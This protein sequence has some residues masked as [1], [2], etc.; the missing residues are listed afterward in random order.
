MWS[1]WTKK[2]SWRRQYYGRRR[3]KGNGYQTWRKDI[4]CV[5]GHKYTNRFDESTNDNKLGIESQGCGFFKP[6]ITQWHT[7]EWEGIYGKI[8]QTKG[9]CE[10]LWR[11]YEFIK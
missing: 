5:K 6:E 2:E 4:R 7:K 10:I 11:T 1:N 3:Q 9:S 8:Q